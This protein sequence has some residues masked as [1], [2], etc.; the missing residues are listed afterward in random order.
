MNK[1]TDAIYANALL[2]WLLK[3]SNLNI[4]STLLEMFCSTIV[5]YN[6]FIVTFGKTNWYGN[7]S[8]QLK[9]RLTE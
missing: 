3:L 1:T 9:A 6:F 4:Y 8:L 2:Y 5:Q 7:V